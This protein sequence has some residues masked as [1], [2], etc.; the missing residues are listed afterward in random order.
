MFTRISVFVL[1]FI[2]PVGVLK[3]CQEHS[4]LSLRPRTKKAYW[5][6]RKAP[7]TTEPG[8]GQVPSIMELAPSSAFIME[9]ISA[10]GFIVELVSVPGSV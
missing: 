5:E 4:I 8:T 9:L 7:F 10:P 1:S 3:P 2:I 6:R